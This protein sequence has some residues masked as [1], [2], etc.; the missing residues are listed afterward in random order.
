MNSL[1]ISKALASLMLASALAVPS[2]ALAQ[3]AG[4]DMHAAGTD[5][6]DAAANTGHAVKRTT[7]KGY[8]KSKR[9]TAKV[10]GKTKEGGTIAVDKTK[11]GTVKGYDKTK[12]GVEK[13]FGDKHEKATAAHDTA[14]NAHMTAKDNVNIDKSKIDANSPH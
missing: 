13:V 1:R 10:A 5:T 14:K 11:E 2:I 6:K 8:H 9:G 12:E 4:Q 7:K 3:T